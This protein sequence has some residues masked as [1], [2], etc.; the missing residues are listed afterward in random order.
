M[1]RIPARCHVFR[2]LHE[3]GCFVIPNPWDRGSA[4]LLAGL[5]F[6]ALATTSSGF[7]CS[8][9]RSDHHASLE[10]TLSHLRS[11]ADAVTV[12]VNADFEGGFAILPADVLANVAAATG[13][14]KDW[15]EDFGK[16]LERDACDRELTV[17]DKKEA[18]TRPEP[19][20]TFLQT[21]A[22]AADGRVSND[23]PICRIFLISRR[24]YSV[25]VRSRESSDLCNST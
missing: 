12:P 13:A 14:D 23:E 20:I 4:R 24:W 6:P 16:L 17:A 9:G 5:G 18:F 19:C 1:T 11:I 21:C 22:K 3:A 8:L 25:C 7:A 2:Q 15:T 10:E